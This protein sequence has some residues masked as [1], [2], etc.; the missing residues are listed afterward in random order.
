MIHEWLKNP[1]DCE[2]TIGYAPI[3]ENDY[4]TWLE[5]SDQMGY[6]L[7]T[8]S[9]PVGYGELWIDEPSQDVELAHLVIDPL[10]RGKG[11]GKQLTDLLFEEGR[12]FYFP[13]AYMRV[14][15]D[16]QAARRCY[17]SVLFKKVQN[18]PP[19]LSNRWEWL[20]RTYSSK[21]REELPC[22]RRKNAG[23]E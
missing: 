5:A 15:P 11:W 16:N 9:R 8:S 4:K 12:R 14:D 20:S 3:K 19:E 23:G 21:N 10:E 17:E 13:V 18:P 7:E 6:I 1:V 2:R 22:L